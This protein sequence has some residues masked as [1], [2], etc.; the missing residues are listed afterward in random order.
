MSGSQPNFQQLSR[1]AFDRYG[2]TQRGIGPAF[3]YSYPTRG[4]SWFLDVLSGSDEIRDRKDLEEFLRGSRASFSHMLELLVRTRS[5]MEEH[6][7]EIE[8]PELDEEVVS[9]QKEISRWT[10]LGTTR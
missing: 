7:A 10:S 4:V 6:L 9:L 2:I 8:N 5:A 3:D 1:V